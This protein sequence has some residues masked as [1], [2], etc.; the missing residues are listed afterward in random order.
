MSVVFTIALIAVLVV[1]LVLP[2]FGQ[3]IGMLAFSYFGAE[4]GFHEIMGGFEMVH[5]TS[6]HFPCFYCTLLG[7]AEFKSTIEKCDARRI[8]CNG[9]MD[10]DFPCIFLLRW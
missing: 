7:C 3:Q 8:F 10:I 4:E 6:T 2:I 9:R 1:A 5:T